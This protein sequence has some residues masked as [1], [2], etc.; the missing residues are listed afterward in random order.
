MNVLLY[1]QALVYFDEL[2]DGQD[3]KW[4]TDCLVFLKTEFFQHPLTLLHALGSSS[5]PSFLFQALTV[6]SGC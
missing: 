1:C 3:S 4:V 2:F 5:H 6:P